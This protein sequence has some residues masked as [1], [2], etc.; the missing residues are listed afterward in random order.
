[1]SAS[2]IAAFAAAPEAASIASNAAE[3][4]GRVGSAAGSGA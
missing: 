4:S 3:T 1:M 2:R